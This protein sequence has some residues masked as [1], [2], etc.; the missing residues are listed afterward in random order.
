MTKTGRNMTDRPL[1][2]VIIPV[3]N[4]GKSVK[5][6]IESLFQQSY[7]NLEIIAVDDGSTDDSLRILQDLAKTDKRL[8]VIHQENGGAGAARNRGLKNATGI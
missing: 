5:A 2:S 3:W 8:K 1:V 7:R 4:T 6:L